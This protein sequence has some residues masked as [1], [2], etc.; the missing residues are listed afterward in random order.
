MLY[1]I[2]ISWPANTWKTTWIKKIREMYNWCWDVE[3]IST[4]ENARKI[5]PKDFQTIS[6]FQNEIA[7]MEKEQLKYLEELSKQYEKKDWFIFIDRTYKDNLAY[8][9]YADRIWMTSC[10][11]WI[12]SLNLYL[13]STQEYDAIVFCHSPIKNVSNPDFVCYD[14]Q[15]FRNLL[16]SIIATNFKNVVHVSNFKDEWD[17]ALKKLLLILPKLENIYNATEWK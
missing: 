17:L 11:R 12:D 13:R 7:S 2:A 1:K 3:I 8:L 5:S 4:L 9:I 16:E 10:S 14:N 6:H 15:E